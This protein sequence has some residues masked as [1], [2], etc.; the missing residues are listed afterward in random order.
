MFSK[1]AFAFVVFAA[2]CNAQNWKM[3]WNDEFDGSSLNRQKWDY[4]VDCW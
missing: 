4:E 1:I 2:F 3:I